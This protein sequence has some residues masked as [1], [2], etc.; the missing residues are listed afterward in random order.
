VSAPRTDVEVALDL[1]HFAL[2]GRHTLEVPAMM[3]KR[4]TTMGFCDQL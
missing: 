2:K 3:A 1:H 4:S